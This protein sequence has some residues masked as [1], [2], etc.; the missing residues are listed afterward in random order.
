MDTV[1]KC[2]SSFLSSFRIMHRHCVYRLPVPSYEVVLLINVR[3]HTGIELYP[4]LL[5]KRSKDSEV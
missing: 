1:H 5:I 4:H 2:P 3:G